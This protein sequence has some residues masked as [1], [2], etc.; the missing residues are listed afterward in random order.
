MRA[1]L[2]ISLE[3]CCWLAGLVLCVFVLAEVVRG[4]VRRTDALQ[5]VEAAWAVD[6]PDMS[7]WSEG[8]KQAWLEA[9]RTGTS[10]LLAVLDIPGLGLEVPVYASASD[11]DMDRGAGW[12]PG[13]S[14]PGELGNIGI[15]GHRDGYF[16]VL[17]D[18]NVGDRLHLRTPAGLEQYEIDDIF[19]V[20][21]L[22]VEILDP[23]DGQTITLVTCYPFYFVGHAPQRYIVRA[24]LTSTD[25]TVTVAGPG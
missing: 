25:E 1:A 11:L 3:R 9:R 17:K 10:D 20:D 15:A 12:I 24:V 14:Q 16:R 6:T 4:E 19:I 13:T 18:A 21:P 23:T 8:R 5:R 22:D 7:L 2:L